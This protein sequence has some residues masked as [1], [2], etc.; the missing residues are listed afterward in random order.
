MIIEK[1]M[2]AYY[3]PDPGQAA[4]WYRDK[5][6]FTIHGDH[7]DDEDFRW[8][9]ASPP[10]DTWQFAFSDVNV[11]G[12]GELADRF[13]AEIGFAPH[14]MLICDDLEVTVRELEDR[15]VEIVTP[16]DD[17]PFGRAA[18]IRDLYGNT[19]TLT[20]EAGWGRLRI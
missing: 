12:E 3:V 6:L 10:G 15:G 7:R 13:R 4:D 18:Y 8:V 14:F 1:A 11:H 20:D 9:T 16:P 17:A 19:I 5:L 2:F